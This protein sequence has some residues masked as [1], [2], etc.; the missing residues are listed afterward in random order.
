MTQA[1]LFNALLGGDPESNSDVVDYYLGVAS[2][3][4][5]DIRN[6]DVV[7]SKYSRLQVQIAIDLYNR[8]G[9]EGQ[10]SHSENGISRTW[11]SSDVSES[12]ISKITPFVKT[13][14]SS[15]RVV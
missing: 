5:C 12:L 15:D 9:A 3:I 8:R 11:S 4:I 10:I 6:S 14:F 1:E 2:D 13:P 7:E